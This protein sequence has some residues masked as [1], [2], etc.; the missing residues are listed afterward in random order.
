MEAFEAESFTVAIVYIKPIELKAITVMLDEVWWGPVSSA[1]GDSNDY[2]MGRI[3]EHNVV[4]V[5]P[6]RGVQGTVASA[7]L[8]STIRLTFPNIIVGFLVGIGGGIPRYPEHDVRLGDVVVGAPEKGPA[9][10]QYDLG[11]RTESGFETRWVLARPP[12]LLLQVVN[13]VET[14]SKCFEDGEYNLLTPHLA[15][16]ARYPRI[17]KE[18]EK[19]CTRD[20]LFKSTYAHEQGT[21]CSA[22]DGLHEVERYAREPCDDIVVH[23]STILSGGSVMKSPTDRD[24]L[25]TKHNNALCIEM[26]AAGLMDIF[27][28]L[29]VRG[30]SD[31]A[32]SHK[33]ETWQGFAAATAAAYAREILVN[34]SKQVTNYGSPIKSDRGSQI[35]YEYGW[36]PNYFGSRDHN[37]HHFALPSS[38]APSLNQLQTK[39][40]TECALYNPKDHPAIAEEEEEDQSSFQV[41]VE[42]IEPQWDA[43]GWLDQK[44]AVQG[45]CPDIPRHSANTLRNMM[46][47]DENIKLGFIQ[48]E[49]QTRSKP[50]DQGVRRTVSYARTSVS[51]DR[52]VVKAFKK[53]YRDLAFIAEEM[54]GQALCKA[55]ALE[56]NALLDL[57]YSLDFVVTA[58]LELRSRAGACISIEP[59]IGGNYVKYNNNCAWVNEDLPDD[60][61]NQAAQAFSHFTFER[62]WGHF[63]VSDLQGVGNLLTGPAIQTKDPE[64]FKLCDANINAEGFKFF[65]ATHKCNALCRK[66]QLKSTGQ[67]LIEGRFEFREEW[68]GVRSRVYCSNKLCRRILRED[69][70]GSDSARKA[71]EFPGYYWCS[72]CFPQLESSMQRRTCAEAYSAEHQFDFSSFFYESQGQAA[73]LKCPEHVEENT[74]D[75]NIGSVGGGLW[76]RMRQQMRE[77]LSLGGDR[78]KYV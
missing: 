73:P 52:F 23:Y 33:N 18:F 8:V 34:M 7:Q 14:K 66:L 6:P 10:V 60:P 69:A 38:M 67:M 32:D 58:A 35:K 63:L 24:M 28:C 59:F 13:K 41:P 50:F 26:E 74:A 44:L 40:Q 78:K 36:I 65:F 51:T 71:S 1:R 46:T 19:P 72:S 37:A 55:F 64:R 39:I 22:H 68:P 54:K 2:I 42:N 62:S 49:I 56:F 61:C 77:S 47:Q 4:L 15:R 9:V 70:G 57:K 43:P 27:P 76:A 5:G 20:R 17:K 48:L 25:S 3:G 29:V 21:K 45:F 11:E 12:R 30:I 16:F 53:D 31:Y 75:S